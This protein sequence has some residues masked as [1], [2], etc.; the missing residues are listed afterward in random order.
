MERSFLS[1]KREINVWVANG[2][3]FWGFYSVIWHQTCHEVELSRGRSMGLKIG[4]TLWLE[5]T[6]IGDKSHVEQALDASVTKNWQDFTGLPMEYYF[7][8]YSFSK[9]E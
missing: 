9:M 2:I 5:S 1:N 7:I 4:L 6:S 8:W 3:V